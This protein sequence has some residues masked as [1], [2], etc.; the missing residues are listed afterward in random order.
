VKW[1]V[2]VEPALLEFEKQ[3]T[4]PLYWARKNPTGK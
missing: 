2:I 3:Q 4:D 1:K